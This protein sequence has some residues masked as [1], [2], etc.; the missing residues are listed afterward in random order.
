M[1]SAKREYLADQVKVIL[2]G[3][4]LR[5]SRTHHYNFKELIKARPFVTMGF[6]AA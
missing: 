1:V 6:G 2:S 5:H 3:A 4:D